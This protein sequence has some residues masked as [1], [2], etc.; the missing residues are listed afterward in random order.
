MKPELEISPLTATPDT[1]TQL[2]AMLVETVA[3][4]GSVGFMYPL[5]PEAAAAFWDGALGAAE[6]GERIILGGWNG[7]QLIGTVTLILN[8][9]PNQPHRAEIAKMM[10]RPQWRGQGVAAALLREAEALAVQNGRTLLVLDTASDEGAAGLY[11][12]AGYIFA[13]ELPDYALKPHGG[14]TGTRL[15]YRRLG[16]K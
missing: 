14:L 2:A 6:R 16:Q 9:P 5:T 7:E 1:R 4:G 11:E 15:Y 12:G 13:G 3:H 10:T 8:T